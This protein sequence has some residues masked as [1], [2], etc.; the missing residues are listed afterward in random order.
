MNKTRCFVRRL[1]IPFASIVLCATSFAAN[2]LQNADFEGSFSSGIATSWQNN[3][4][5]TVTV[6]FAQESAEPHKGA[7]SQKITTSGVGANSAMQFKQNVA[8]TAE[9]IYRVRVVLRSDQA[10]LNV[11]IQLRKMN[12]PYQSYVAKTVAVNKG[13]QTFTFVGVAPV[14]DAS[15]FFM[16]RQES[17]GVLWVDD[18]SLEDLGGSNLLNGG[19]ENGFSSG[20]GNSWTSASTGTVTFSAETTSPNYGLFAQK[21]VAAAGAVGQLQQTSQPLT[22]GHIYRVTAALKASSS[23][24]VNLQLLSASGSIYAMRALSVTTAWQRFEI[25]LLAPLSDSAAVLNI[26][27]SGSATVWV[28]DVSIVDQGTSLLNNGTF[29]GTYTNGVA[30]N[31]FDNS[32][33]GSVPVYSVDTGEGFGSAQKIVV[34][35]TVN[36]PAYFRQGAVSIAKGHAYRIQFSVKCLSPSPIMIEAQLRSLG[37]PL[38]SHLTRVVSPSTSWQTFSWEGPVFKDQT[39]ALLGIR[40]VQPDTIWIDNFFII[41]LGV[42]DLDLDI[43]PP[44]TQMPDKMFGLHVLQPAGTGRFPTIAVSAWRLWDTGVTWPYLK[45]T[46]QLDWNWHSLDAIQQQADTDGADLILPLALSPYWA[47]AR[48]SESSAYQPGSPLGLGWAAEPA[49]IS[50]WQTYVSTLASHVNAWSWT[51]NPDSARVFEIWNEV[52]QVKF[53]SGQL[54]ALANLVSSARTQLLAVN[55]NNK[56]LSPSVVGSPAFLDALH[57]ATDSN[58]NSIAQMTDIISYHFYNYED[59]EYFLPVIQDLKDVIAAN[60]NL[61]GKPLWNTEFGMYIQDVSPVISTVAPQWTA[62]QAGDFLA[63]AYVLY[64]AMGV[65]RSYY[66]AWDHTTLGLFQT[67]SYTPKTEAVNGYDSMRTWLTGNTMTDCRRTWDGMWIVKLLTPTLATEYIVWQPDATVSESWNLPSG[68]TQML[69]RSSSTP[70]SVSG[71]VM[72]TTTPILLQ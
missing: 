24:P 37:A 27:F 69:T 56:I 12:T 32:P 22:A 58:G 21:I 1:A 38:T 28:D 44:T 55:S 66:Y 34:S 20:I 10:A 43:I 40:I 46:T 23:T 30:Q 45:Q 18:A 53:F 57:R 47:S 54:S 14:T 15:A 6:A 64:W 41:D 19:F 70:I 51:T 67:N 9:H 4:T 52:N 31:W 26:Q 17:A 2:L 71:S 49:N 35:N 16:L 42:C 61:S 36:G 63:R 72:V 39:D 59:P 62:S 8:L 68:I 7:A 65:E 33:N 25:D 60:S 29:E 13:W 11:K 3:S 48:S 5:G 50:D